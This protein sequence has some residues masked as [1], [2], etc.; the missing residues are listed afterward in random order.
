MSAL[1]DFRP[2]V[3][4]LKH[5][6]QRD[7]SVRDRFNKQGTEPVVKLIE[8]RN[9]CV[10]R[11]D[12]IVN[13]NFSNTRRGHLVPK[14]SSTTSQA[15]Y[16]WAERDRYHP[17]NPRLRATNGKN[18]WRSLKGEITEMDIWFLEYM[19][20][21]STKGAGE[22]QHIHPAHTPQLSYASPRDV[23]ILRHEHSSERTKYGVGQ[24]ISFGP[25]CSEFEKPSG[26][27]FTECMQ[28]SVDGLPDLPHGSRPPRPSAPLTTMERGYL[29][30]RDIHARARSRA[31]SGGVV[32][33][34]M[35][36]LRRHRIDGAGGPPNRRGLGGLAGPRAQLAPWYCESERIRNGTPRRTERKRSAP[37]GAEQTHLHPTHHAVQQRNNKQGTMEYHAPPPQ[38]MYGM[39]IDR[40]AERYGG[41]E[42]QS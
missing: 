30:R 23:D 24:R 10:H 17:N 27:K 11:G 1:N 3:S 7:R 35:G 14:E 36:D 6:H 8:E 37:G 32:D 16:M 18:N 5:A 22:R 13:Y 33:V 21:T 25:E 15:Q 41:R 2:K 31:D 38:C 42:W 9:N 34:S 39:K 28:C 40:K 19:N 26:S 20:A 12:N 29:R 4:H